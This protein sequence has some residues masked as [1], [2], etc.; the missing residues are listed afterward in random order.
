[1]TSLGSSASH[2]WNS[3]CYP[4]GMS[5]I[6]DKRVIDWLIPALLTGIAGSL[7]WLSSSV[8]ELSGSVREVVVTLDAHER[9]LQ[10]LETL[11]FTKQP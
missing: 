9:R 5:E 4:F 3:L 1:M 2:C 8:S 6:T 7:M 11:F 10:N